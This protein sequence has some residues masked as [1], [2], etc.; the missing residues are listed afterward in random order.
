MHDPPK[1]LTSNVIT[2]SWF[3]TGA[4]SVM[5]KQSRFSAIAMVSLALFIAL[6][7][8]PAV[9]AQETVIDGKRFM[10]ENGKLYPMIKNAWTSL[11]GTVH[12]SWITDYSKWE[13]P[14]TKEM[15]LPPHK[16]LNVQPGKVPETRGRSGDSPAS[17][18][19]V[20]DVGSKHYITIGADVLFDFD[21][22]ELN[23]KAEE[24][25]L[26]VGPMITK[27]GSCSLFIDGHT[28]SI[29]TDEY[30]QVLSEK[31]ANAVKDW[32]LAHQ[33]IKGPVSTHGLGKS[34]PVAPNTYNDGTDFPA[35]RAKNRRVEILVDT[36]VADSAVQKETSPQ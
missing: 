8:C 31:R 6:N 35:G 19:A 18:I 2:S 13:A 20:K 24:V 33:F 29:G 27:Y 10:Q 1:F 30:N 4:T 21:K 11:D 34:C 3:C 22:S 28:D 16:P 14:R 9:N 7:N 26:A 17:A 32:L 12:E 5:Q 15:V 36:A 23:K 25:M